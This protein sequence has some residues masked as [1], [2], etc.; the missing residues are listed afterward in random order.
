MPR[1]KSTVVLSKSRKASNKSKNQTSA[2]K[3]KTKEKRIKNITTENEKLEEKI[4]SSNI[5]TIKSTHENDSDKIK[6]VKLKDEFIIPENLIRLMP[7][8]SNIDYQN[9][10][11][12]NEF[13]IS[14]IPWITNKTILSSGIEKLN[15]EILDF[16]DLIKPTNSENALK[17]KT[18]YQ[19]QKIIKNKWPNW[20]AH[21]FGSFPVNLHLPDSDIDVCVVLEKTCTSNNFDSLLRE[22][23]IPKSVTLENIYFELKNNKFGENL[24]LI[25]ASVP[26]IKGRCKETGVK[27]DIS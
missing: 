22:M 12:N 16:Y 17:E 1:K 7:N 10:I 26:I 9:Y 2:P 25:G 4:T 27:M 6:P 8:N 19:F 13:Q 18:F 14:S 11:I 24:T 20:K 23:I 3:Q 5:L 15:N 21:I